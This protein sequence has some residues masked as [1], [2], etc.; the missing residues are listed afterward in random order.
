MATS[1]AA[2]FDQQTGDTGDSSNELH[3]I[4]KKNN[5]SDIWKYF[6]LRVN[7]DDKVVDYLFIH[8]CLFISLFLN[9]GFNYFNAQL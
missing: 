7:E 4:D 1:L 3:L 5:K 9:Q 8:L 2:S 6:A